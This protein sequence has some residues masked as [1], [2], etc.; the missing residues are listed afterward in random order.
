[1]EIRKVNKY[2]GFKPLTNEVREQGWV[3]HFTGRDYSKT[4]LRDNVSKYMLLNTK[5]AGFIDEL[6]PMMV[7]LV[8]DVKYIRNFTNICVPKDYKKIN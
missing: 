3:V 1:M 6:T 7:E 4:L 8:D 2:K 5:M